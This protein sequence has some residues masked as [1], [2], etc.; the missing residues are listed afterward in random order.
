MRRLLI[1]RGAPGAGKTTLAHQL[2]LAHH[3]L[4]A[5]RLRELIASPE[6]SP[7]GGWGLSQNHDRQVWSWL[8]ELLDARMARGELIVVDATHPHPT[9]LTRYVELAHQ[10]R[11]QLLCVDFSAVPLERCLASN[12]QR[13]EPFVV[14]EAA[15][16]RI[17]A[18]CL[19]HAPPADLPR[20]DW[21]ADGT[22]VEAVRAFLSVP[23]RDLSA[24]DRVLHIGD[25]QGC[26]SVLTGRGGWLEHGLRDDTFYVFVGDFCDRGPDNAGVLRALEGWLPRD[27][28]AALWGNHEDHLHRMS[29]GL[30]VHDPE[31][32]G[33]TQPQLVEAGFDAA[34]LDALLDRLVQA[35][36]YRWRGQHV[37][38]THAGLPTVPARLVDVSARQ[39]AHGPGHY[40]DPV[41]A[42]FARAAPRADSGA[43]WVQVHGHRNPDLLPVGASTTSFN[44]EGHVEHGG[45]LRGL[46]LD[47]HGWTP[48]ERRNLDF[49]PLQQRLAERRSLDLTPVPAWA[50]EPVTSTQIPVDELAA[51]IDH[52]LV[53]V[54]E[55]RDHPSVV[56][57]NFTR[58][59]FLSATWDE[60]TLRARGL[61][62][63]I[64]TCEIVARSYDKF[65]NVGERPETRL[66]ALVKRLQWP[67]K[68]YVKEN[69][70]L[71]ILGYDRRRDA[72][73]WASKSSLDS[74]FATWFQTI[75]SG[76]LGPAGLER[77]LRTLRDTHS[78]MVFEVIEPRQDPHLI[79]YDRPH[80]VLL[81]VIR[82]APHYESLPYD[83]LVSLAR[84]LKL[85]PKR[86]ATL[87]P[88]AKA[89][90]G[91]V[92][93][94][95]G[96]DYTWSGA[97][98]EGFVLEDAAG[99]QT[100]LKLDF[101]QFWKRMRS[102]KD[103]IRQVRGTARP[104]QRDVAEPRVH[105]F[106]IWCLDQP[107]EVLAQDII[108]L[109]E[110][111]L[112]DD[113]TRPA[114]PV[115]PEPPAPDTS[116]YERALAWVQ[117]NLAEGG[118]IKPTTATQLLQ[119]AAAQDAC[120]AVLQAS[121][122]AMTLV[123]AAP[124]GDARTEVGLRLELGLDEATP[125]E[126]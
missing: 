97:P 20:I 9:D 64:E 123:S 73:L 56:S 80:A 17:H 11:Y 113:G 27:N 49:V 94:T 19:E 89:L 68:V 78:S 92:Q 65:F 110:A 124:P 47:E 120:L 102:L 112:A 18:A 126:P 125:D 116:G 61:F 115:A 76:Q 21:Q 41:D 31:F 67:V 104:L 45:H 114:S 85:T 3:V 23:V 59:A 7:T 69:G 6:L 91:F 95:S 8:R 38:V 4:S 29:R 16:R 13:P 22:H 14:P 52:P 35:F 109:R 53:K 122:L 103:R 106:Y 34:R 99:Y 98:I 62:I 57:V 55:Q 48:L 101:Y 87:L 117:A 54:R 32:T 88:D 105:A 108:T 111:F 37:L 81:D 10:H 96:P 75:V 26:A 43:P 25:L 63:D 44:L 30:V 77:V 93:A 28:V 100:K 51:A 121:G 5:D 90:R 79:A 86:F 107:D 71:G 36:P 1:T 82:R 72:L 24:Y 60:V 50:R 74:E 70:Y 58:D 42:R 12:T 83:Q 40:N 15:V 46:L 2:G 119:R 118:R 39:L 66:D 84:R 33:F